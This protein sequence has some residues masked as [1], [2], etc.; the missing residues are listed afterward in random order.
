[1]FIFCPC[2]VALCASKVRHRLGSENVSWCL[3]TSLFFKTHFRGWSSVPTLL[4]FFFCLLYFFLALFEELGCFSGCLMSSAGIQKL[5]CGIYSTFKCSFDEF[6][7]EKVFSLSYSSVILAPPSAPFLYK[8]SDGLGKEN[9]RREWNEDSVP[10]MKD[11][12]SQ[13]STEHLLCLAFL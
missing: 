4:S 11:V 10:A 5:F 6:V 13:F 2:Y 3:E 1:M 8:G 9:G 12:S 7:G